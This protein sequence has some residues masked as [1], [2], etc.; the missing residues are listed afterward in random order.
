LAQLDY[1]SMTINTRQRVA[2]V[3]GSSSGIG[4]ETSLALARNRFHTFATMR[5]LEKSSNIT[6]ASRNENL[7]L[8][9][10]QLDVNNEKSVIEGINRIS[11][12]NERVD[13]V[14]NN[15]GYDITGPLEETS[16]DKIKAQYETSRVLI[17][18]ICYAS[19]SVFL[20]LCTI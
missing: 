20:R 1:S 19:N 9:A 16:M 8:Q 4:F 12:E 18:D 2:V 14:V 17:I 11:E 7:P 5:N 6:G 13:V 3:T 10:I 15:A